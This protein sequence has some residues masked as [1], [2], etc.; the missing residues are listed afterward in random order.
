MFQQIH[1]QVVVA[2]DGPNDG[3]STQGLDVSQGRF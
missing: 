1:H 3:V 2:K